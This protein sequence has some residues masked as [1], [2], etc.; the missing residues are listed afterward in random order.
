MATKQ[1]P[2]TIPVLTSWSYSR[3]SDYKQ[4]PL[5]FKLKHIDKHKE[6]SNKAMDRG[7]S[8]HTLAE[9][10]IKGK[11]KTLAPELK[12]FAAELKALRAMYRKDPGSMCVEDN[13]AFKADW[14]QTQWNNWAE[15]WLRIKL[16]CAHHADEST[17][18]ITDWKS[19]K[20]NEYNNAEYSEQL[21]LYALAAFLIH[22]WLETV[23]PRLAYL[24]H[25]IVYP[26]VNSDAEKKMT[27]T[28]ADVPRLKKIWLARVK[29]MFLDKTFAPRPND[30][31][32]WCW[33]GQS[34]KDLG[35]GKNAAGFPG[36]PGLCK[37]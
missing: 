29:A 8:M 16:D 21:E 25:G 17:M 28:K 19:G 27:F 37:Y 20:Y 10:Y 24:D 32:T 9:L 1:K 22:D 2:I 33:F 18:I 4:C 36:G 13:W 26:A 31:C 3:L 30:K 35:N 7:S 14:S 15:C 34:K 5:K 6:P 12:L 11:E 23:K